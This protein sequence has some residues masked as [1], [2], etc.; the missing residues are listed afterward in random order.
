MAHRQHSDSDLISALRRARRELGETPSSTA[1]EAFAR[2]HELPRALTIINRF[3]GWNASLRRA[4][5]KPRFTPGEYAVRACARCDEDSYARGLCQ[6]H[7]LSYMQRNGGALA[8]RGKYV[9][10]AVRGKRSLEHRVVME[11]KLGRPLLEGE[12]VHHKNGV[13]HDN[14]P[15]NL[16]LRVSHPQGMSTGDAV[17]W[18]REILERYG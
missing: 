7:Y 1:Y 2:E 6:R 17:R 9:F 3:G 12:T 16:E 13:R 11:A 14:R 4:G 5:M 10:V 18:A 15:K 8:H